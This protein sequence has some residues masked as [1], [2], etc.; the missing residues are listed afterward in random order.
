MSGDDA[1]PL[2]EQYAD[3]LAACDEALAAGREGATSLEG[4]GIPP[5][6]RQALAEDV[7]CLRLL[8]EM[9]PQPVPSGQSSAQEP[10][11]GPRP[12]S[13]APVAQLGRF[14][15]RR[16][17]GHG[18]YGLVYLAYD[19][20]L[21]REVALKVPRVEALLTAELR[22]RF[23]RESRAGAGL[24]HPNLVAV[25]EAGEA[26]PVCYIASAYCPGPTLAAWLKERTEPV[27]VPLAA[28]LVATLAEAVQHAHGRGVLHRDLKPSNVLLEINGG[29]SA[30]DGKQGDTVLPFTPKVTDF[31]LA[32]VLGGEQA[33]QTGSGTIVGTPSHM[34]PEQ[35]AG[36]G[37]DVGPTTDV[38]AL[39]VILYQLLTGRPPFQ[40]ES[41]LDL[42]EQVRTQEPVPPSSLR[43]KL[44]RDVETVCLKCLE[45]E[46]GRRYATAAA[47]AEDLRRWLRGEPIRARPVSAPEHLWRW[48]RRNPR[49]ADLSAAVVLLLVAVAATSSALAWQAEANAAEVR[50]DMEQQQ[51]SYRLVEEGTRHKMQWQFRKAL[52]D[53]AEAI[54]LRPDNPLGWSGRASVYEQTGL[55]DRAADGMAKAFELFGSNEASLW[56]EHAQLRLYAGDTDGYRAACA[57]MYERFEKPDPRTSWWIVSACTVGPNG[58]DPARLVEKAE[59]SLWADPQSLLYRL[60]LGVALYRAGSFEQ[61]LRTLDEVT[62]TDNGWT[63]SEAWPVQAMAH[64]RLG[65]PDEARQWLDRTRGGLEETI[66]SVQRAP[67]DPW[68]TTRNKFD[69][70]STYLLYREAEA[71]VGGSPPADHPLRW[72]VQGRGYAC[73]GRPEEAAACFTRAIELRPAD[74]KLWLVRASYFVRLGKEQEA[75]ADYAEAFSLGP[76]PDQWL[77]Y[78]RALLCLQVGHTDDYRRLCRDALERYHPTAEDSWLAQHLALMCLIAPDAVQDMDSPVRFAEQAVA[79]DPGNPWFL[80]TLAAARHRAGFS[81]EAILYLHW[82]LLQRWPDPTFEDSGRALASLLLSLA[83]ERVGRAEEARHWLEEAMARMEQ[84]TPR[85]DT[86]DL[87]E[88]WH[89]WAACRI[90]HREAEALPDLAPRADPS[91]RPTAPPDLAAAVIDRALEQR[92]KDPRVWLTCAHLHFRQGRWDRAAVD[93]KQAFAVRPSDHYWE[94]YLYATLLLWAGDTDAYRAACKEML[95]RFDNVEHD[96]PWMC[97]ALALICFLAPDAVVDVQVPAHL[98]EVSVAAE[99]EN[100]WFLLTL[101]AAHYRTGRLREA[102]DVL[103]RALKGRW[104]EE[105][106]SRVCGTALIHLFLSL[107]LYRLGEVEEARQRVKDA[108]ESLAHA[109]S[110]E[111]GKGNRGKECHIW[112]ACQ[113]LRREAETQLGAGPR[114]R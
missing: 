17:L 69:L 87:G 25:Y 75:A 51:H 34:A 33:D 16:E 102:A 97:Q 20:L 106:E 54:T 85:E 24:D 92:P 82:A 101:G 7:S 37:K 10:P 55:W 41:V 18:S 47:L 2:D 11:A 46:P 64:Q 83:Y 112:A 111:E 30:P 79:S 99:P 91:A 21:R 95:A 6:V 26:G 62:R 76:P 19:P 1:T 42:L 93:F 104:P 4:P 84:V 73:L 105:E 89:V 59:G 77:C 36:K 70:L 43:S 14:E 13:D 8:R 81:A 57:A 94:W 60:W 27:P 49:L 48:C 71:V 28:A 109:A 45:K 78:C 114:P 90:L 35:A 44:P 63:M 88:A 12:P 66:W 113:I 68:G 108:A 61:A 22:A 38:Y 65:Q 72:V 67:F 32:K 86:G 52:A 40:A 5:E 80:L 58:I 9:F 3:W 100:A 29:V 110:E 15:L 98:A 56:A 107:A 53:Y 50:R 31:G 39:G 74:P 103:H 96:Q 23:L